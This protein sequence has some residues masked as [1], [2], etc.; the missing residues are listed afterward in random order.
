MRPRTHTS[1]LVLRRTRLS[2]PPFEFRKSVCR[3]GEQ[4]YRFLLPLRKPERLLY[5]T[6][7]PPDCV[8]GDDF[9][10][11]VAAFPV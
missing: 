9:P 4:T 2:D 11:G 5:G 8:L 6:V 3:F 1:P 7:L 10:V